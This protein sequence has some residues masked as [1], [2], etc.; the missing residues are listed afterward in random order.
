MFNPKVE[1]SILQRTYK[2][3]CSGYKCPALPSD[4]WK[5]PC[6]FLGILRWHCGLGLSLL[7]A[8]FCKALP[9]TKMLQTLSG[10]MQITRGRNAKDRAQGQQA[11]LRL[12]SQNARQSRPCS[13]NYA[14]LV[15]QWSRHIAGNSVAV[16]HDHSPVSY[17]SR[18]VKKPWRFSSISLPLW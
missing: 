4:K 14:K 9:A 17:R 2:M 10:K 15:C 7:L 3:I 1:Q 11:N 12:Q 5:L 13:L 8:T 6:R 16:E 18:G